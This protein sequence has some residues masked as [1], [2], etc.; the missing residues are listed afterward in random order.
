MLAPN[1]SSSISSRLR[2]LLERSTSGLADDA[3]D[4]ARAAGADAAG[5]AI[6]EV[7][8]TELSRPTADGAAIRAAHLAH[9]LRLT[10][11]VPALVRC[12]ERLVDAHPLRDAALTVLARFGAP[13][14][15]ALLATFDRCTTPGERSQIALALSRTRSEDDRIRATF[16]RMLEEDPMVAAHLLEE[17]GEW[18]AIPDLARALD[19]LVRAPV[20]DCDLCSS[21]HLRAIA[22]AIRRL[23][24]TLSEAQVA[25]LDRCLE[26]SEG[27]WTRFVDPDA[28]CDE[29]ERPAARAARPGRNDPCHCGSGKKYKRCHLESDDRAR[30]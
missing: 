17:H 9:A 23:G 2:S 11:A 5:D 15:D 24:G 10:R 21:E 28:S 4:E 7:L 27:M 19:R 30:N 8:D 29:P 14:V 12:V 22:A 26:R 1:A 3:I 13:G 18:R 16:V 25:A 20:G 6:A